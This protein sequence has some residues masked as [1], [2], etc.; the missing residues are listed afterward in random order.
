MQ[1]QFTSA[2][3]QL[4]KGTEALNAPDRFRVGLGILQDR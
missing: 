2:G 4:F 3:E 1:P